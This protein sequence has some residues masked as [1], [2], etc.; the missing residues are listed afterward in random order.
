VNTCLTHYEDGENFILHPQGIKIG[1]TIISS[2][3]VPILVG[4]ALPL[5]VV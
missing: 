2:T 1:S 3:N 4:N 5:S